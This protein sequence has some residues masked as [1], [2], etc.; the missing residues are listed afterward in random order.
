[1][2]ASTNFGFYDDHELYSSESE[3]STS[4]PCTLPT[5]TPGGYAETFNEQTSSIDF[6]INDVPLS[7]CG[8]IQLDESDSSSFDD[9]EDLQHFAKIQI[10]LHSRPHNRRILF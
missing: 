8:S 4:E 7:D 5:Y 3:T 9:F 6:D 2:S 1:M 10:S